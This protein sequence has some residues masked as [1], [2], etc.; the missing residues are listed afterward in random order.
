M[1][2]NKEKIIISLITVLVFVFSSGVCAAAFSMED[3]DPNSDDAA[4]IR[5][6]G[7]NDTSDGEGIALPE[8]TYE[9]GYDVTAD[10]GI[11][12]YDPDTGEYYGARPADKDTRVPVRE[13]LKDGLCVP[14][15]KYVAVEDGFP[16]QLD[17]SVIEESMAEFYRMTGVQPYLIIR[18]R[19][20]DEDADG[21]NNGGIVSEYESL[22]SDEG[23]LL[24]IF[25]EYGSYTNYDA[26]CYAG[27]DAADVADHN[28]CEKLCEYV[29]L[30]SDNGL[31][32]EDTFCRSFEKG[33]EYIMY[34]TE[35]DIINGYFKEDTV[36]EPEYYRPTEEPPV[37]VGSLSDYTNSV[38][39]VI[40]LVV[41]CAVFG[42][43]ILLII[44]SAVKKNAE[45]RK[46]YAAASGG[47]KKSAKKKA[48]KA[49]DLKDAANEEAA[50][51]CPNCGAENCLGEDGCCR[52]CGIKLK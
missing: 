15:D 7:G 4:D 46:N 13:P 36:R 37:T 24:F 9:N 19:D 23:H 1:I 40:V 21:E 33:A 42:F 14:F 35:C 50:A 8:G 10:S 12:I 26:D 2:S 44:G 25:T 38:S 52:F 20:A 27:A 34:G 16:S 48:V 3:F 31:T 22:F 39:G 41:L 28:G 49:P 30:C 43:S 18:N 47:G 32:Y 17:T 6:A 5:W 45:D 29:R 11:Y 51:C